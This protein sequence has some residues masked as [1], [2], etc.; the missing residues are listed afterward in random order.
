MLGSVMFRL[1]SMKL[2]SCLDSLA[3][4]VHFCL[5]RIWFEVFCLSWKTWTSPNRVSL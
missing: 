3:V 5:K 1:V 4:L 2:W